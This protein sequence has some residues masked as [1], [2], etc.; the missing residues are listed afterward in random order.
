MLSIGENKSVII[1]GL[2]AALVLRIPAITTSAATLHP[3]IKIDLVK[4][5]KEI[6]GWVS[7]GFQRWD[8]SQKN[9]VK[10]ALPA[11][12][13]D[14]VEIASVK[15]TIGSTLRDYDTKPFSEYQLQQQTHA[16][17]SLV[18]RLHENVS[19][20]DP[21]WKSKNIE[22]LAAL[23]TEVI[24]RSGTLRIAE[25]IVASD[26]T[27]PERGSI[28]YGIDIKDFGERQTHEADELLILAK[29]LSETIK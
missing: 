1:A 3:E 24:T 20:V 23:D 5:M 4:A 26:R 2:L 25:A 9:T 11:V 21:A 27:P 18:Y 29:N 22:T 19:L 6:A 14:L 10:M 7:A 16:L 28:L 17:A 13:S 12:I 8:E 15:R